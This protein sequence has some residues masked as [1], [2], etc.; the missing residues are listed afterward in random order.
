MVKINPHEASLLSSLS[1]GAREWL[2]TLDEED[3]KE[4]FESTFALKVGRQI[5]AY[6]LDPA[7]PEDLDRT[8]VGRAARSI[9][10]RAGA[11]ESS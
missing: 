1:L 11:L 6:R 4:R 8:R 3:L 5:L 7:D 10:M 2:L 9:L